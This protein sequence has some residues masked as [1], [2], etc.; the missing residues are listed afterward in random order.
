MKEEFGYCM[1]VRVTKRNT[2]FIK[3]NNNLRLVRKM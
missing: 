3:R 1:A 2:I